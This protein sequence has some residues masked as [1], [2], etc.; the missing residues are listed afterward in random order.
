MACL[1][2]DFSLFFLLPLFS[3]PLL[4]SLPFFPP[5][6]LRFPHF[7]PFFSLSTSRGKP[8]PLNTHGTDRQL[9]SPFGN[10]SFE[11]QAC[12]DGRSGRREGRPSGP[13]TR[14]TPRPARRITATSQAT[15]ASGPAALERGAPRGTTQKVTGRRVA[16]FDHR[17]SRQKRWHELR[18]LRREPKRL[19]RPLRRKPVVP[20]GPLASFDTSENG[21]SGSDADRAL[22]RSR[23]RSRSGRSSA[24]STSA[25]SD[26]DRRSSTRSARASSFDTGGAFRRSSAAAASAATR[27]ASAAS[28][29]C[30]RRRRGEA[31]SRRW[32]IS[33]LPQPSSGDGFSELRGRPWGLRPREGLE[34]A[35]ERTPPPPS[36]AAA[37]FPLSSRA[38]CPARRSWARPSRAC[39]RGSR[40]A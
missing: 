14:P 23:D 37:P 36:S 10:T 13:A 11:R 12:S 5:I 26:V 25:L 35:K 29:S 2:C 4:F 40:P 16:S 28:S 24:S 31:G 18:H 32:R 21:C 3:S 27:A 7:F 1:H 38:A 20:S 6:S 15:R 9:L 19:D 17:G 39:T 8:S 34:G 33:G 30:F 22:S